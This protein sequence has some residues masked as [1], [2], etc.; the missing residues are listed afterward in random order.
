MKRN[1]ENIRK[2]RNERRNDM[3]VKQNIS[4]NFSRTEIMKRERKYRRL[5]QEANSTTMPKQQS[6]EKQIMKQNKSEGGIEHKRFEKG[7]SK[8]NKRKAKTI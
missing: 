7:K 8:N 5:Y 6:K 4:E 3:A 1:G 2:T